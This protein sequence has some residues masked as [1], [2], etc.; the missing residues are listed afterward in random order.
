MCGVLFALIYHQVRKD[1]SLDSCVT[2]WIF[3]I[4]KKYFSLA[5]LCLVTDLLGYYAPFPLSL[6][7][8]ICSAD[9]KNPAN[10]VLCILS[11]FE[12]VDS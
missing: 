10:C 9:I 12:D 5:R 2:V 6:L 11:P 1:Y 4:S 8:A 3:I 7:M